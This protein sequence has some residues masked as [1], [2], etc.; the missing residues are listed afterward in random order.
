MSFAVRTNESPMEFEYQSPK[1][2]TDDVF[3]PSKK[4][5]KDQSSQNG[6]LF[7]T[8]VRQPLS[9]MNF[10]FN[11]GTPTTPNRTEPI[12]LSK[13]VSEEHDSESYASPTDEV[14]VKTR[15]VQ[16]T[17]RSLRKRKAEDNKYRR[18][19]SASDLSES[20]GE[21]ELLSGNS[22]LDGVAYNADMPYIISGWL[23]LFF[24]LFLI[25]VI[26]YIILQFI[27]TV[28]R[29]IDI[30]VE[31]YSM[32]ILEE[33]GKCSHDYIA[34]QC[35]P[36]ESRLPGLKDLCNTWETCMRRDPTVIGRAKVSAETFAEILNN[37][38]EPISYKTMVF[39]T[40]LIFGSLFLSN[41]A[42]GFLRSRTRHDYQYY[43]QNEPVHQPTRPRNT[44]RR[45]NSRYLKSR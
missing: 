15:A 24:N 18:S 36:A 42:F 37:F 13:S 29:D 7:S 38:V 12:G 19:V 22:L 30:K 40:L 23:Q 2:L 45:T 44:P 26:L 9:N 43:L 41:F 5:T 27:Y 1:P 28:Q 10:V 32:A 16:L 4:P 39:F 33:I 35:A 21:H 11:S 34:N 31:E 3:S 25:A 14:D 20:E 8:P 6:G 17:K